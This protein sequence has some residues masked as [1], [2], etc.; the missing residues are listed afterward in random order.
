MEKQLLDLAGSLSP[1]LP[2]ATGYHTLPAETRPDSL[3]PDQLNTPAAVIEFA[4][5]ADGRGFSL[6]QHLRRREQFTG[7]LYAAGALIPDQVRQVFATGFDG[8]VLDTEQL[9]R[10]GRAHW[11]AA[12]EP[13]VQSLYWRSSRVQQN[14]IWD[15]RR[16]GR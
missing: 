3:D 8:I 4:S 7:A 14:D 16:L 15:I 9:A 12:A 11:Q 1:R 6:A 5:T 10:Y 13:L 2:T